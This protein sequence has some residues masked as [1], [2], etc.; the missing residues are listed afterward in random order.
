MNKTVVFIIIMVVAIAVFDF[1]I[2]FEAGAKESISAYIIRW[3]HE[4]PS[5][6][7]LTGFTMGNLF[8]RMNDKRVYGEK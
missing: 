7:F 3:S 6:P 4:Y 5:I 2:I 1:Y 8:W